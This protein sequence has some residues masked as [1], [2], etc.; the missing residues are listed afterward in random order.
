VAHGE[1]KFTGDLKAITARN[2]AVITLTKRVTRAPVS[3]QS[4]GSAQNIAGI[5]DDSGRFLV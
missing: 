4:N 1:G 3:V 2:I 5:C